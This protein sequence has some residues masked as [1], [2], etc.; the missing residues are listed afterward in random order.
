MKTKLSIFFIALSILLT[1]CIGKEKSPELKEM[2]ITYVTSPLNVPSILEK[3]QHIFSSLLPET[4]INYAE[5]TSG[6]EQTQALASENVQVLYA[7][8]GSSVVLGA[9]N[10]LDIKIISMYSRAPKAFALYSRDKNLNS[11]ES[12]KGKTIAG[13]AG[14]N[15]HELLVAYLAKEN[16]KME[17]VKFI[18]MGIPEA[19]AALEGGSVDVAMLGG[20]AAYK[21]QEAG[22][23]KVSDGEGLIDAIIAV[24]STQKFIEEHPEVIEKIKEGQ[25]K[26]AKE[27]EKNPSEVKAVVSKVLNIDDKAFDAMYP[28]YDFSPEIHEQDIQGLQKTADFMK[29]NHMIEKEVDV[30]EIFKK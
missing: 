12:L 1:A 10:G 11:P 18:N 9:A 27:M 30:K 23:H 16:L 22:Y 21:A 26:I 2:T 13:P 15:L 29:A 8:G 20:P 24:A 6:A 7:V 5:I 28:M 4:K 14:T 19:M 17:D 3:E 25:K